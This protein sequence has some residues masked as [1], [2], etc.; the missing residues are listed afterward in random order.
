MIQMDFAKN[1]TFLYQDEVA[2]ARWKK[3]SDTLVTVMILFEKESISMVIVSDNKHHNKRTV[4]PYLFT[5]FNYV[6]EMFRENIQNI[7]IRTDMAHL[8]NF[9]RSLPLAA[10]VITFLGCFFIIIKSW[11]GG[12]GC[13]GGTI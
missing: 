1:F 2:S 12:F 10:L 7:N 13:F 6:K 9:N 3:K 5:V 4:V 11:K 8:V